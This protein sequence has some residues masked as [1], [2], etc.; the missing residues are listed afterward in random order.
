MA[1]DEGGQLDGQPA[2]EATLR[3][4]FASHPT[5]HYVSKIREVRFLSPDVSVL[6]AVAE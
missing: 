6:R 2:I 3:D 4:I 1:D 5:P